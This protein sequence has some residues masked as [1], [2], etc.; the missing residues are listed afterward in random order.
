M[1]YEINHPGLRAPAEPRASADASIFSTE[2][3]PGAGATGRLYQVGLTAREAGALSR[4]KGR[5][6]LPDLYSHGGEFDALIGQVILLF[7]GMLVLT[8][9]YFIVPAPAVVALSGL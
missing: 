4:A 9:I 3:H 1:T 6:S 8:W 7:A 5:N 2:L